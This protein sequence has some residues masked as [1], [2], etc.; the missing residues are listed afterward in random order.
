VRQ[1][2]I[3]VPAFATGLANPTLKTNQ[4]RP[5]LGYAD[6]TQFRSDSNSNYNAL[7]ISGT[8]RKGDLVATLSYTYSKVLGQTG[9]INDNPEPECPFSCLLANGQ[10]VSWRQFYYGPLGFDRR[11]IFVATYSYSL[12]FFRTQK[13]VVG[14]ALGGWSFSGITRAQSGQPLTVSGNQTIG[15]G[16]SQFSRRAN[17]GSGAACTGGSLCWFDTSTYVKASNSS[18]GNAPTGSIIGPGYYAWDMSLRKSFRLP[19]EGTNLTFQ[20]DAFNIF[21]R[22]NWQNPGTSVSAGNFGLLANTNPPR[23]LQFGGRF[24]F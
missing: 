10:T 17:V 9:G 18:A 15:P 24:T 3:N 5:F 21:N 6:I 14:Q 4:I 16:G 8:K 22:T 11:N 20:A 12:P 7:Q 2:N 19:L 23:Q 1:P 13:G